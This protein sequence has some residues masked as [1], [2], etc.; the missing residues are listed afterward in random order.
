MYR[1]VLGCRGARRVLR[2]GR[3]SWGG[4]GGWGAWN[5]QYLLLRQFGVVKWQN[6]RIP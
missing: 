3:Y 6:G 1:N 5:L 2:V 4:G